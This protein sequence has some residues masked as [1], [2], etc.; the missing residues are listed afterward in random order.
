MPSFCVQILAKIMA[1]S[2]ILVDIVGA[3]CPYTFR[4]WC[5]DLVFSHGGR[6][7]LIRIRQQPVNSQFSPL[8]KVA[9]L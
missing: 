4:F 3:I 5:V 1:A 2:W 6:F 9:L 8:Q 7:D